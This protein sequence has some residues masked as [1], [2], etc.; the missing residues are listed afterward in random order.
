[1]VCGCPARIENARGM[2]ASRDE[3]VKCTFDRRFLARFSRV[4]PPFAGENQTAFRPRQSGVLEF[5]GGF[6]KTPNAP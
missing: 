5:V 4:S 6:A 2:D 3:A 1:M